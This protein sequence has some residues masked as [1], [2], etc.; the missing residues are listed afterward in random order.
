M[1]DDIISDD[2]KEIRINGIPKPLHQDLFNIAKNVGVDMSSL[3]KPVLRE[4]ADRYPDKY[5]LPREKL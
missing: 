4:L 5:K 1:N 3:I 2:R